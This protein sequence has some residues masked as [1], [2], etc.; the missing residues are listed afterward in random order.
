MNFDLLLLNW[1]AS[2]TTENEAP[3]HGAFRSKTFRVI[4]EQAPSTSK[5]SCL[6]LL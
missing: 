3:E 5:A 6:Q 2:L 1:N 4:Q